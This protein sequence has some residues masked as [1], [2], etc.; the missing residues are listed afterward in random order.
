MIDPSILISFLPGIVFAIASSF[1]GLKVGDLIGLVLQI[2]FFIPMARKRSFNRFKFLFIHS[3][4]IG[5][6]F[7]AI[8]RHKRVL[9]ET[10]AKAKVLSRS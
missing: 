4:A 10:K 9:D 3:L 5:C 8:I 6:I 1:F 2:A 7:L